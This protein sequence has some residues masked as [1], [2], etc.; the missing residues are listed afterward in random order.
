MNPLQKLAAIADAYEK[1]ALDDEARRFW[2]LDYQHENETP[3]KDIIL[4]QGRGGKILLN[5][6]DCFDARQSMKEIQE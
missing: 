6:Q 4:Y 1:N 3:F 2:G 5:L